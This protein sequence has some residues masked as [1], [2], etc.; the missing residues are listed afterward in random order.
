MRIFG[1]QPPGALQRIQIG[2]PGLAGFLLEI[3][4]DRSDGI[5]QPSLHVFQENPHIA[6]GQ[7]TEIGALGVVHRIGARLRELAAL[8]VDIA[9]RGLAVA[10]DL[11]EGIE[12]LDQRE[13]EMRPVGNAVRLV[14]V[15]ARR[16]A[17]E[18][19]ALIKT[20]VDAWSKPQKGVGADPP[21]GIALYFLQHAARGLD[22]LFAFL[23]AG[24]G[25]QAHCHR[26][27]QVDGLGL[28]GQGGQEDAGCQEGVGE[29]CEFHRGAPS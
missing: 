7:V 20:A 19:A 29:S 11:A 10:F 14:G 13:V 26:L 18:G 24:I 25:S 4:L 2:L 1:Q 23:D 17:R 21:A 15:G 8:E 22:H 6:R 9:L 12:R 28:R 16:R 5:V 27:L 3:A